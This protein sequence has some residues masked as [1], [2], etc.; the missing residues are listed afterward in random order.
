MT[1]PSRPLEGRLALITGVSR[2]NGIGF[3]IAKHLAHLGAKLVIQAHPAFDQKNYQTDVGEVD[4]VQEA[5]AGLTPTLQVVADFVDPLAPTMVL[6][7]AR[8]LGH[9]DIL[10]ANH[11]YSVEDSISTLTAESVDHHLM[12]NVRSTLLLIQGFI[13]Q[14]DG[15]DGGRVVLFTSGQDLGAMTDVVSYAASK[16]ALSGLLPTLSHE[17]IRRKITVNAVDPG[18]TDTGWATEELKAQIA[19]SSPLG[20]WGQPDDAARL[21]SWLCTDE[22]RWIT[23]EVIHSRGGF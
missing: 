21:V 2:R 14:H 8:E 10:V 7:A 15:R 23:G 19:Q 20:R 22:A 1:L 4:L 18:P 12:V 13:Q 17:L 16:G 6:Q 5:L 11:A 9:I 3:A